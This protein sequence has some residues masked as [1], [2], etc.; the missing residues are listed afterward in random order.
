MM[1][2]ITL[3]L[4]A[5][6]I[7]AYMQLIIGVAM[8]KAVALFLGLQGTVFLASALSPPRDDIKLDRPTGLLKR[9]RWEFSEGRT[10]NYPIHY[11]P[12]FFYGGFLLLALSFV[13]SEIPG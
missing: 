13:L 1:V 9:L 8:I 12:M 6:I 4:A 3:S 11:N 10:L 7:A 2:L 5:L